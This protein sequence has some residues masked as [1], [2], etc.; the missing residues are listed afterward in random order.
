M[1]GACTLAAVIPVEATIDTVRKVL[2][3]RVNAYL[4]D[5]KGVEI[6]KSWLLFTMFGLAVEFDLV[7]EEAAVEVKVQI[8][9]LQSTFGLEL[10]NDKEEPGPN[11]LVR[12]NSRCRFEVCIFSILRNA[13]HEPFTFRHQERA[14]APGTLLAENSLDTNMRS[15][16]FTSGEA[17]R[18]TTPIIFSYSDD[19]RSKRDFMNIST[20]KTERQQFNHPGEGGILGMGANAIVHRVELEAV[21]KEP[22]M[23][24]RQLRNLRRSTLEERLRDPK[25]FPKA[26][27]TPSKRK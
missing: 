1:S 19:V 4:R 20:N 15:W 27:E 3:E 2:L 11:T 14:G 13:Q 5:T 10:I 23:V 21:E 17:F 12:W 25:S 9:R 26:L 22:Q 7:L 8:A 6:G 24:H 18:S 16:D